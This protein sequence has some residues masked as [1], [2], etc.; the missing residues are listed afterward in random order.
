MKRTIALVVL[1][2]V[3][4][5]SSSDSPLLA[6][7]ETQN[8]DSEA[9][10]VAAGWTGLLN[11]DVDQTSDYGFSDS[12][13]T[14]GS[15]GEAGGV[16][17]FGTD[18]LTYYADTSI[19]TLNTASDV[20]S[21]SG[22]L[23][24]TETAIGVNGGIEIGFFSTS[25]TETQ[26]SGVKSFVGVR[27]YEP[28]PFPEVRWR[29]RAVSQF[30]SGPLEGPEGLAPGTEYLF[31]IEYDPNAIMPGFGLVTTEFRFASD[32]SVLATSNSVVD[33]TS[34]VDLDA[35]GMMTLDFDRIRI[36]A[37]IFLDELTYTS[38]D[39]VSI[40]G[41]FDGDGDVD[42]VD[43]LKWQAGESPDPLS[44]SDLALWQD[45]Y[46]T[47]PALAAATAIPEP[48][49][50]VLLILGIAVALNG[51]TDTKYRT[52]AKVESSRQAY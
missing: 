24:V 45:N 1:T 3:V 20:L 50:S 21:A 11:R 8:F 43:F 38:A 32:D 33:S 35:F 51:R 4:I 36:G 30:G 12:N 37:T 17:P 18:E 5:L 34:G 26:N 28:H 19:G 39:S 47:P 14:G 49:S 42:G 7:T 46:G 10:A 40:D 13:N 23:T 27:L 44:A 16:I 31:S 15:S 29:T 22:R 6:A 52:H 41:D 48:S 9:D 25:D 2:G